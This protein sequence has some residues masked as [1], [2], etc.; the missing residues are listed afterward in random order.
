MECKQP[1]SAITRCWD[2]ACATP[3]ARKNAALV[4]SVVRH[5]CRLLGHIRPTD[6][7][8]SRRKAVKKSGNLDAML[9]YP[10]ICVTLLPVEKMNRFAKPRLKRASDWAHQFC[11]I[12]FCWKI[13]KVTLVVFQCTPSSPG[14]L[15]SSACFSCDLAQCLECPNGTHLRCQP[16]DTCTD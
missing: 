3:R 9:P 5:W 8:N 11:K 15:A 4:V 16:P 2:R 1:W 14:R 6:R 13:R 10:P 7:T 12:D